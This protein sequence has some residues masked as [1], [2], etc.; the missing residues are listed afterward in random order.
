MGNSGDQSDDSDRDFLVA[1]YTAS[2]IPDHEFGTD[3]ILNTD[4]DQRSD[5]A[6]SMLLTSDGKLLAGGSSWL[7]D[8]DMA[9]SRY[10]LCLLCD[11]FEDGLFDWTLPKGQWVETDG[12]LVG[13]GAP[14]AS[15]YAP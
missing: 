9:L 3:G 14:R 1:R 6:H 8:S 5:A 2:G 11:D 10:L 15:I 7:I 12:K 4:F 13:V